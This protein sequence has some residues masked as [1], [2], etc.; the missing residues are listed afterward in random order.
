MMSGRILSVAQKLSKDFT[1]E[2]LNFKSISTDTRSIAKGALFV[3]LEG[4]NFDGNEFIS[5]A[6]RKGAIAAIVSKKLKSN[7]PQ[8]EVEDTKI[9]LGILA[10]SWRSNFKLP[11]IAITGSNGKTTV[12]ELISSIFKQ[13][14]KICI[15]RENNNNEVGLPMT[16]IDL[17][18]KDEVLVLE[19]G[20]NHPGEI[21]YLSSIAEP[22]IGLI[23]NVGPS[24]L[25]GFGSVNDVAKA[26]GEIL[27]YLSPIDGTAIINADDSFYSYWKNKSK[28][29]NTITFGTDENAD[30]FIASQI[31][32]INGNSLFKICLPDK[33]LI[34]VDL[35][36]LGS[37]NILNALAAS[38]VGYI[39]GIKPKDIVS[40]LSS[41]KKVKGRL[42]PLLG[43]KKSTILDDTYNANPISTKAAIDYLSSF[44]G[45]RIFIFG[46]MAELG[47][48]KEKFHSEIGRYAIGKCDIFFTIGDLA[49]LASIEFGSGSESFDNKTKLISRI[50]SYLDKDV[51]VLV[52]GSRFMKM[53]SII[54]ELVQ[55]N[56]G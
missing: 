50:E 11:V 35:P 1:G 42:C 7:L 26:K 55:K 32:Y 22:T 18:E 53:E 46:D 23:T 37:H 29:R 38:L 34:D 25:E 9:A 41:V 31:E 10:K 24:H 13:T 51:M 4:K 33:T 8:I 3:A 39:S 52:K 56:D 54:D 49:K 14:Y 20:A 12:K 48:S 47:S 21:S 19:L 36:L 15:T 17:E 45:K 5:E 27:D 43:K 28:A 30:C 44:E 40:G 16:L 6:E 2:N